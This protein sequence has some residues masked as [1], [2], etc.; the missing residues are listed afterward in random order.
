MSIKLKTTKKRSGICGENENYEQ[1]RNKF[2]CYP[3]DDK[4]SIAEKMYTFTLKNKEEE[5]LFEEKN[6]KIKTETFAINQ[7]FFGLQR[8]LPLTGN[9]TQN[10]FSKTGNLTNI[11]IAEIKNNQDLKTQL[12]GNNSDIFVELTETIE[13][14]VTSVSSTSQTKHI[15]I[16][17]KQ[18]GIKIC[19]YPKK[20]SEC[21]TAWDHIVPIDSQGAADVQFT[22][23]EIEAFP[24]IN[25][26]VEIN[27]DDL[28]SFIKTVSDRY[29]FN[30]G[31]TFEISNEAQQYNNW[32]LEM[33]KRFN[34]VYLPYFID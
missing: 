21:A 1:L 30:D 14:K 4:I 5:K 24:L 33:M 2:V 32:K 16:S 6:V 20:S 22:K 28:N 31:S 11:I 7:A 12:S 9:V 23:N 25:E 29:Y 15:S 26:D 18:S 13:K 17:T 8:S 10:I 19:F 3:I 34:E 27:T